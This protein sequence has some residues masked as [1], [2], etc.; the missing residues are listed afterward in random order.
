MRNIL[1]RQ[2]SPNAPPNINT[3]AF[4]VPNIKKK[5]LVQHLPLS[6][7]FSSSFHQQMH[8]ILGPIYTAYMQYT[9][10]E[11]FELFRVRQAGTHPS[12]H[13][14]K[15][16][17]TST[18][19]I[20]SPISLICLSLDNWRIPKCFFVWSYTNL[21]KRLWVSKYLPLLGH[22]TRNF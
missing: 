12:M 10:S 6:H 19:H 13:W 16:R 11:T 17:E 18:T 3:F 4:T 22:Q 8:L 14:A 5:R 1:S 7:T 9:Y 15:G 20:S 2:H 21:L